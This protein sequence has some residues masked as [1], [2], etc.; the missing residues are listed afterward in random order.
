MTAAPAAADGQAFYGR[1]AIPGVICG[2]RVRFR[3]QA[4]IKDGAP[5]MINPAYEL[6][7]PGAG[8]SQE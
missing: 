7:A 2:A 5:V 6:L 3:G 8:T 1:S 4:G